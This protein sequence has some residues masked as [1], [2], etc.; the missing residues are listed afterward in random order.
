MEWVAGG[1]SERLASHGIAEWTL[2]NVDKTIVDNEC[3]AMN[4]REG[5][6]FARDG[7]CLLDGEA[8]KQ[9]RTLK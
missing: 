5:E 2:L 7:L 9:Q 1:H 8:Q 4:Q 6:N 3:A